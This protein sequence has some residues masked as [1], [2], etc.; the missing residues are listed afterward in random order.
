M[1][2]GQTLLLPGLP[3]AKY[4]IYEQP[5][6]TAGIFAD[7]TTIG[8]A[9]L[10]ARPILGRDFRP[11]EDV[12][13]HEHVVLINEGFWRRRFG[14]DPTILG[15]K[16]NLDGRLYEVIGV[17]PADFPFPH[18]LTL[19]AFGGRDRRVDFWKPMAFDPPEID[20]PFGPMEFEAIGR[21]APDYTPEQG[22]DELN[23]ISPAIS[24]G[25]PNASEIQIRSAPLKDN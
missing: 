7:G 20:P 12:N 9:V 19:E 16:L 22:R 11:E 2:E 6:V 3:P 10:G 17:I 4:V 15:K 25:D 14:A 21:L 23:R 5:I 13:G 24:Q 18:T 1:M 8:D